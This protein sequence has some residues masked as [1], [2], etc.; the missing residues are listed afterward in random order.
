[1]LLKGLKDM[2]VNTGWGKSLSF[3]KDLK[4]PDVR[5]DDY[6]QFPQG[7]GKS[8]NYLSLEKLS[9]YSLYIMD[10]NYVK[11]MGFVEAQKKKAAEKKAAEKKSKKRKTKDGAGSDGSDDGSG[12]EL[13]KTA[14]AAK[15]SKK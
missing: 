9:K 2:T 3:K 14:S 1:V 10:G 12:G 7:T 15:K 11:A 5:T 8:K 4:I 13:L 6:E